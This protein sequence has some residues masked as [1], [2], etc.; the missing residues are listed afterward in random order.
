[1]WKTKG[2]EDGVNSYIVDFPYKVV[3][4][5]ITKGW[6]SNKLT[7]NTDVAMFTMYNPDPNL[8]DPENNNKL[9]DYIYPGEYNTTQKILNFD[10]DF[11]KYQQQRK[12]NSYSGE[13]GVGSEEDDLYSPFNYRGNWA[14]LVEVAWEQRN[15]SAKYPQP[16]FN[17]TN[18][19]AARK[20]AKKYLQ[21]DDRKLEWIGDLI[22]V[23]DWESLGFAGK[24]ERLLA[25]GGHH[26]RTDY[27]GFVKDRIIDLKWDPTPNS[28]SIGH[29]Y[30]LNRDIYFLH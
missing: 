23:K 6:E 1:M 21:D 4:P 13:S 24:Q 28:L 12:Y 14:K 26:L 3:V 29:D 18:L 30:L 19:D 10:F 7:N 9:K 17:F 11:V 27:F 20:S 25:F 22:P 5:V 16:I 15:K 2:K 8:D